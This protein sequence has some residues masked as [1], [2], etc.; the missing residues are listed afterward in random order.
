M[1]RRRNNQRID[2]EVWLAILVN[3]AALWIAYTNLQ[4]NRLQAYQSARIADQLNRL[5]QSTLMIDINNQINKE[6]LK[7]EE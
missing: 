2:A 6:T 7:K 3:A 5:N 4:Y 1:Y